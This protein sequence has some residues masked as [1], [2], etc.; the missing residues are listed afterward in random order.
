[1][2]K[3]VEI[4]LLWR[5][6]YVC[7]FTS[8]LVTAVLPSRNIYSN[9][10]TYN[11]VEKK[12][13]TNHRIFLDVKYLHCNESVVVGRLTLIVDFSVAVTVARCET[14]RR[15]CAGTNSTRTLVSWHSWYQWLPGVP[16]GWTR[17]AFWGWLR[18]ICAYI[19]VS[20]IV[21]TSKIQ[22]FVNF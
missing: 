12:R 9:Y 15:R 13:T 17:P 20:F 6:F 16:S 19:K 2:K 10:T 4:Y 1:M 5:K 21:Q 14:G 22:F 8:G 18:R 7:V 3:S 11:P